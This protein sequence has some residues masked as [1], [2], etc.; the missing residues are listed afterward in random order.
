MESFC[1]ESIKINYKEKNIGSCK[2][3]VC[4]MLKHQYK[5]ENNLTYICYGVTQN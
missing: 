4:L 3:M 5:D 1:E 2:I